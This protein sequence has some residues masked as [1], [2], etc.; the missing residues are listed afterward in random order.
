LLNDMLLRTTFPKDTMN[1]VQTITQIYEK[2]EDQQ[3]REL[4]EEIRALK[5]QKEAEAEAFRA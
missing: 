5:E 1:L 2:E 4:Q 3:A